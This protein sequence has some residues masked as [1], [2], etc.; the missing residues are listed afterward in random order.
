MGTERVYGANVEASYSGAMMKIGEKCEQM[1]LEWAKGLPNKSW[2][3]CDVRDR[4]DY[5]S[6]KIDFLIRWPQQPERGIR[7]IDVKRN[8]RIGTTGNVLVEYERIYHQTGTSREG[9]VLTSEADDL[10]YINDVSK[11]MFV[12]A[13]ADLKAYFLAHRAELKPVV[14]P[15][16]TSKTT[17]CAL[18]PLSAFSYRIVNL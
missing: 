15:S 7:A 2:E 9:W 1:W 4:K 13:M 10:V 11:K 12:F 8:A 5:Q 18:L 17:Y 14:I 3:F 6:K 16:D